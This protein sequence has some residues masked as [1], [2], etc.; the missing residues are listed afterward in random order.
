MM[1]DAMKHSWVGGLAFVAVLAATAAAQDGEG[2][3]KAAPEFRGTILSLDAE[4]GRI[5]IRRGGDGSWDFNLKIGANAAVLIDG[6]EAKLSDLPRGA[7]VACRLSADEEEVL[8]VRAEGR[9]VGGTVRSFDVAGKTITLAGGEDGDRTYPLAEGASLPEVR[10]GDRVTVKFS[11]DGKRVVGVTAGRG[12]KEGGDGKKE[13]RRRA[14]GDREGG[15]RKREEGKRD[16]D[17]E[18]EGRKDANRKRE[19]GDGEGKREEGKR[20]GDR[21]GEGRN[22][23]EGKGDRGKEGRRPEGG[24]E[25]E[26]RR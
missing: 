14:D 12:G 10:G 25:D 8:V 26:D 11:A 5:S 13:A 6:Q 17:R 22:K 7:V 20:D 18:G 19:G 23:D 15:E 4:G 24:D 2:K 3:R 16:G 9:A 21:E 1:E